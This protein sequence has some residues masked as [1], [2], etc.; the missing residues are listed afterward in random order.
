MLWVRRHP[1]Q[2]YT[3]QDANIQPRTISNTNRENKS[4]I[5]DD[6]MVDAGKSHSKQQM[7]EEPEDTLL[8]RRVP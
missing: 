3:D 8:I 4:H 6:D 2:R 5:Q 1:K 7:N